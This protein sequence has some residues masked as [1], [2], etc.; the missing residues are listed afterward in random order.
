MLPIFEG[1]L[2]VEDSI[3]ACHSCWMCRH[4]CP[5]GNETGREED[6]P[7]GFVL[8]AFGLRQG[9]LEPTAEVVDILDRCVDCRL[10][11]DWCVSRFRPWEVVEEARKSIDRPSS[12]SAAAPIPENWT[13]APTLLTGG[14]SD[15]EVEAALRLVRLHEPEAEAVTADFGYLAKMTGDAEGGE[16][17]LAGALAALSASRTET[18]LA[19]SPLDARTLED[20]HSR[21]DFPK[22]VAVTDLLT[23]L[24]ARPLPV[25]SPVQAV[26]VA[27]HDA[28][29]GNR[30]AARVDAARNL[31][32]RLDGVSVVELPWHGDAA[33]SCGQGGG[34]PLRQPDLAGRLAAARLAEA[35]EAGATLVLAEGPEC[36]AHLRTH[37][38][39]TKLG[40]SSIYELLAESL[41]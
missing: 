1:A 11:T 21:P 36:R 2:S 19:L 27:Y 23:W 17:Q 14:A 28:C 9:M 7:R 24:A 34:L 13:S 37:A 35:E 8:T 31:L 25:R 12:L 40:V 15:R 6:T 39:A 20:A 41:K 18:L 38:A 3:D 22:G 29:S 33:Q 26:T 10:C 30:E 4:I 32:A 16:H 5:V